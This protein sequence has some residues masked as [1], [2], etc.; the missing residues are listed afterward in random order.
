MLKVKKVKKNSIAHDLGIEVGDEIVAFENFECED[1]LELV[2]L[3]WENTEVV[4]S[5]QECASLELSLL[6]VGVLH[7]HDLGDS[8]HVAEGVVDSLDFSLASESELTGKFQF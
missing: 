2:L 6:V 7:E 8:S 3:W 4:E 1:E 5:S